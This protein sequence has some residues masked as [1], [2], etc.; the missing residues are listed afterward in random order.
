MERETNISGEATAS[1]AIDTEVHKEP[2]VDVSMSS[3]PPIIIEKL[4]ELINDKESQ[5]RKCMIVQRIRRKK[6]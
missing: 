2:K 1:M 4:K 6:I 3:K 5:F